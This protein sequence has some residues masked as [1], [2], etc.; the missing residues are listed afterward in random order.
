VAAPADRAGLEWALAL[1]DEVVALT[2]APPRAAALLA[3]ALARGAHRAIRVW[4]DALAGADLAATARVVAAAA[5]QLEPGLVVA[6]ERGLAGAGG[7]LPALVAAHLGWAWL[8]GAVRLGRDGDGVLGERRLAR[9]R[10]E[11]VLLPCPA[12]VGV[13]AGSAEPRYVSVRA[14]RAAAGRGHEVWGLDAL[15]LDPGALAA[16]TRLRVVRVDWPR[17]RPRRTA[18]PGPPGSAA[19]RLRQ[20]L[21]GSATRAAAPAADAGPRRVEGEPAA[22][23]DRILAF[24][25]QN[26]FA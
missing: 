8:D 19:E 5:G 20:L 25:V 14:R 26:G 23:A 22:V 1:A 15:G 24:L 12:V 13:A 7:M 6:G 11:E 21:G 4:D 16:W 2:V 9:G 18:T 10:R 17:P 3:W